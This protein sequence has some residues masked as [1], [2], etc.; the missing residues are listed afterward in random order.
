MEIATEAATG[1]RLVVADHVAVQEDV[2]LGGM[3]GITRPGFGVL[4]GLDSGINGGGIAPGTLGDAPGGTGLA[5]MA[6]G[7]RAA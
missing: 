7:H 5:A 3:P 6:M 4:L 1:T 2:E